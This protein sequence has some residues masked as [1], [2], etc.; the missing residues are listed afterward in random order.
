MSGFE[1]L[2]LSG[3]RLRPGPLVPLGEETSRAALVLAVFAGKK[4]ARPTGRAFQEIAR[5]W[6][7]A[8]LPTGESL[9]RW[10]GV[11]L[12]ALSFVKLAGSCEKAAARMF[13]EGVRVYRM[14]PAR[15]PS[16]LPFSCPVLLFGKG[17]LDLDRCY[18]SVFNSRKSR[19]IA[20]D[21]AWVRSLRKVLDGAHA[22]GMALLSS[23]GTAAYELTSALAERTGAPLA[24]V[25]PFGIGGLAGARSY[26][27]FG[28]LSSEAS[29]LSCSIGAPGCAKETRMV[30]RD[31]LLAFLA[32]V[33]CVLD[34]RAGGNLYAVLSRQQEAGPR[35]QIIVKT[36]PRS[37]PNEGAFLLEERFPGSAAWAP[38]AGPALS[39]RGMPSRKGVRQG[40]PFLKPSAAPAPVSPD[41]YLYHYTRSCPGPWPGQS[42]LDYLR[43]LLDSDPLG[44][45]SALD[46]LVRILREMRVRGGVRLV[47]GSEPVVSWTAKPPLEL[48]RIRKWSPALIRW[49]FEPY[50]IAVRRT[51][52]RAVGVK[53]AVYGR[54]QIYDALKASERYRFQRNEPPAGTWK[55]EHE[56]RL[57]GDLGFDRLLPG[58][59]FVF[60]PAQEDRKRLTSLCRCPFPVLTLVEMEQ[61]TG[62]K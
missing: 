52:L 22:K 19:N 32:H 5:K 42:R 37:R 38:P 39:E 60:V 61:L 27:L 44:G 11:S 23:V 56:W 12:P 13:S 21:E 1:D 8:G 16:G 20:P 54:A 35:T 58:D 34:V 3:Q 31:G 25:V 18:L 45:H 59:A 36:A 47:R 29:V 26:P 28:E 33:H 50:G 49:T 40:G 15:D 6:L 62:A 51:V 24:L 10:A 53:P 46:T 43:D 7:E 41:R 48:D 30:C 2:L 4:G 57:R 14:N 9:L 17:P 55:H